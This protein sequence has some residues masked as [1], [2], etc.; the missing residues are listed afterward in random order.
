LA[1]TSNAAPDIRTIGPGPSSNVEGV[2]CIQA[3]FKIEPDGQ[4]G[5]QTYTAVKNFQQ[6]HPPLTVDGAVGRA[7]GDLLLHS[8]PDGCVAHVPS[9]YSTQDWVSTPTP[10]QP[11]SRAELRTKADELM[12]MDYL[13]F[14]Q[15]K[16]SAQDPAFNF[17]WHSDG[18]SGPGLAKYVRPIYRALFD[19]PCQQHDFGYRNY[20][21]HTGGLQL[22]PDENARAWIDGRFVDEMNRLCDRNFSGVVQTYNDIFCKGQA[23]S[24]YT[25][26][27]NGARSSF[28]D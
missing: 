9:T 25:A 16:Q 12:N 23:S 5:Q 22:Q 17:N 10:G 8:A 1:A 20:G 24:M 11:T 6:Q 7:T 27:R 19:R 21:R 13:T 2:K 4:F 3:A 18:C 28:Y 26:I 14:I 15:N